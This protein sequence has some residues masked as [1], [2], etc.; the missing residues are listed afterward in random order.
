MEKEM[1]VEATGIAIFHSSCAPARARALPVIGA[2]DRYIATLKA[3][4]ARCTFTNALLLQQL[5]NA[6]LAFYNFC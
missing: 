3:A 5:E 6:R 2:V 1:M 4:R